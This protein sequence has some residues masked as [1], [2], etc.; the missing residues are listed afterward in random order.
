[1]STSECFVFIQMPGSLEVVTAGRFRHEVLPDGS[2]VGLFVYGNRYLARPD[3]VPLDSFNLPLE[4]TEFETTKL[5]GMFGAL[6]DVAPDSWGRRVIDRR[7]PDRDLTEFDYLVHGGSG[8]IGAL[9]FGPDVEPPAPGAGGTLPGL[10]DLAELRRAAGLIEADQPVTE[11]LQEMLDPGSSVGGA[12]P[13]T[14]IQED[15]VTWLAKFPQRGDPWCNATVEGGMLRLAARCGICVPEVRIEPLGRERILLVRRF[16]R[17]PVEGGEFRR[18]MVSALTVLDLDDSVTDRAGWSYLAFAD[19]IQRW[20]ENPVSD[21]R[22][23]FLRITFNALISNL[24]D[25]PRN[26]AMLAAG[27]GWRL[28]PAYDLTP[29][30]SR[31]LEH[32][33]LAMVFGTLGRVASRENLLSEAPRFGLEVAEANDAIDCLKAVIKDHWCTEILAASGT[34]EDCE[35]TRGA[36]LYPGFEIERT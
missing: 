32:R 30:R 22:E 16:D 34:E 2:S 13:K 29:S 35:A 28:S 23:L 31:S 27:E 12:R 14:V 6:R 18:R 10:H 24:D 3:A 17:E 5:N 21:K 33:D 4:P 19:E 9:S 8:R 26:H 15:G 1:M 25:H 36:F 11:D 20:S 7:Y